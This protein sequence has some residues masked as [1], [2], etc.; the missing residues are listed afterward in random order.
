MVQ[1]SHS[2]IRWNTTIFWQPC[3]LVSASGFVLGAKVKHSTSVT[4]ICVCAFKWFCAQRQSLGTLL[5]HTYCI[6]AVYQ[7]DTFC[8]SAFL[9]ATMAEDCQCQNINN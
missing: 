8:L 6:Q 5:K 2:Q 7:D 9:S 3:Y 4:V 1:P